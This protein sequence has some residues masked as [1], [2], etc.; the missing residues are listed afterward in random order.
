MRENDAMPSR[1]LVLVSGEGTLLQQL[2][3]ACAARTINANVVAAGADRDG[4]KAI[5]RAQAAGIPTFI[6]RVADR[7]DRADWDKALTYCCAQYKPDL[8]VAAGFLKLF[9]PVF[10]DEFGGRCINSHP[11]LLPAFPGMHGIRDALGYGVKVTGCTVFMVDAGL[12]SGPV[13]AQAPV[14]IQ[15]GD[16]EESLTERVKQAE[17]ALLTETV[18][19]MVSRGWSVNGRR[20]EIGGGTRR[21]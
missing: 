15:D 3:D 12:D 9:G 11:A 18:A 16:D 5:R 10:L 21:P 14:A 7:H 8:I 6:C 17:R 1:L 19:A 2:I 13:I 20:V 4:T